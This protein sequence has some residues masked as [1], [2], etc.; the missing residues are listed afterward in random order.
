MKK[1]VLF[2]GIFFCVAWIVFAQFETG[3]SLL[4]KFEEKEDWVKTGKNAW[5]Y[6]FAGGYIIG[7]F[8]AYSG[9]L[10]VPENVIREQ[11]YDIA[12]K[13]IKEN[14]ERRHEKASVLLL[15]AFKKAFPKN[16]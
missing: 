15:E 5:G 4:A 1:L 2:A 11:V 7:I 8:D 13:F 14:P 12:I 3:N 9:I 6:P 16:D 10:A